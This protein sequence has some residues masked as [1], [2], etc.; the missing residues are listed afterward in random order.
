MKKVLWRMATCV[1]VV[2]LS[3]VIYSC[4]GDDDNDMGKTEESTGKGAVTITSIQAQRKTTTGYQINITLNT[5][6]VLAGEI[7]SLGACGGTTSDAN[8]Y[9]TAYVAGGKISGSCMIVAG[10]KGKT[11]YYIKGFLRTSSGTVY[12]SIKRVTT[13]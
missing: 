6:G 9:L 3:Y 10:L 1:A 4:S 12:S 5:S 11:T 8:G 2:L 7:Q 13:P